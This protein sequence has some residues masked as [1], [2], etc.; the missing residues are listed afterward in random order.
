M[1]LPKQKFDGR[2]DPA[3]ETEHEDEAD[4]AEPKRQ[5]GVY[6]LKAS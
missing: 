3:S 2:S 1:H 4:G 5:L 6:S